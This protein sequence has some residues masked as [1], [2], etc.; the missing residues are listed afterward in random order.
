[1]DADHV[2]STTS[3]QPSPSAHERLRQRVRI[4]NL[5]V[6]MNA[7]SS[8][9]VTD[10]VTPLF[11]HIFSLS[12]HSMNGYINGDEWRCQ[13]LEIIDIHQSQQHRDRA[14]YFWIVATA[15]QQAQ[16]PI[17]C[18]CDFRCVHNDSSDSAYPVYTAYPFYVVHR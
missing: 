5:P 18:N 16:L 6:Q 10:H 4:R 11:D 15:V 2:T 17:R 3:S 9:S 7:R 8:T 1:M 12:I 13:V 14:H